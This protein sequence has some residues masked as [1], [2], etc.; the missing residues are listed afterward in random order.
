M[1]NSLRYA[2][3]TVIMA[4]SAQELKLLLNKINDVGKRNSLNINI[5]KTKFMVVSRNNYPYINIT[6]DKLNKQHF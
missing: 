1:L 6:I 4:G 2:D 5:G 3:D